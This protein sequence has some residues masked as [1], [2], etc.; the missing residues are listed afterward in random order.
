MAPLMAIA[1]FHSWLWRIPFM[2]MA[3]S[4]YGHGAFRSWL[5]RIPFMA[6]AHFIHGYGAIPFMAK[7]PIHG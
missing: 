4:I 7:A 3:H 2:A 1:L 5:W 6:M